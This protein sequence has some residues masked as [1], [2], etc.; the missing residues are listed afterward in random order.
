MDDPAELERAL[1]QLTALGTA[2]VLE[3]GKLLGEL[4]GFHYELRR[5]GKHPLL[6]LWSDER[7]LVR[8]IL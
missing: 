8:R 5:E 4:S 2:E 1:E 6:H 7:N 3:D